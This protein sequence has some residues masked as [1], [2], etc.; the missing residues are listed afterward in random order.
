VDH[1]HN[2]YLELLADTG[3]MGG[4]CGLG[5]IALLLWQGLK[6]LESA[7]WGSARAIRGGSL[8]ACAGLLIHSLVDFNLHIPSNA[9]L[10]LLLAGAATAKISEPSPLRY[11]LSTPDPLATPATANRPRQFVT[12]FQA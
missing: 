5:F 4:L 8:A 12:T 9:L 2:D 7:K 1:A 6:R 10:F 11:K 3:L